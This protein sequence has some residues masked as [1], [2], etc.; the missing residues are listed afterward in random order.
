MKGMNALLMLLTVGFAACENTTT[1]SPEVNTSTLILNFQSTFDSQ[2]LVMLGSDYAYEGGVDVKF[3]LFQFFISSVKLIDQSGNIGPEVKDVA[4]ISF[5]GINTI[6]SSRQGV[7][8]TIPDLP[9]GDYQGIQLGIGVN[10]ALNSTQPKEYAIGHPLSTH[11][12]DAANS[13][14]FTKIEGVA[15]TNN[16]GTYEQKLTF[17][18]G[19]DPRYR[20]VN[21]DQPLSLATNASTT[22]GF[23]VDVRDIFVGNDGTYIDFN[24]MTQIHNGDMPAAVAMMDRFSIAL[25]LQN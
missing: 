18:I 12:W 13:Y 11:Y 2:P 7:S 14:I 20:E 15:D 25:Q 19:G 23:T 21:F 1:T 16:D 9:I 17:H 6:D 22:V 10:N 24:E 8:I 3:Q 5:E 4:L